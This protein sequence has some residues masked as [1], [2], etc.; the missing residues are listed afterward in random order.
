MTSPESPSALLER[1]AA[2]IEQRAADATEGPWEVHGGGGT[3][4]ARIEEEPKPPPHPGI[5]QRPF[6]YA[7]F[8][9][10]AT[11]GYDEGGF[12]RDEDALWVVLM[13]PSVAPPLVEW[14][15]KTAQHFAGMDEVHP[16]DPAVLAQRPG[17]YGYEAV[18]FA[19]AVLG[20]T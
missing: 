16:L 8:K 13:Q 3:V 12:A 9:P 7:D 20:E 19:R 5:R 6:R 1:A 11:S 4:W 2:L 18:R 15:R 17:Q 10:V 14:L